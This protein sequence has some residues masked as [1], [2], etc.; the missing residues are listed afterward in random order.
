MK[1]KF[2]FALCAAIF[3]NTIVCFL[4]TS[5]YVHAKTNSKNDVSYKTEL[6][7]EATLLFRPRIDTYLFEDDILAYVREDRIYYLLVD[8]IDILALSI[9]YDE[10]SRKGAGWFLRED[11]RIQLDF[12]NKKVVSKDQ[13]YD[14]TD[15]DFLIFDDM[16]YVSAQGLS[17]W[18]ALE[19]TPDIEQQYVQVKSAYPVPAYARYLRGQKQFIKKQNLTVTTLP[20]HPI[21]YD[22]LDLNTANI[23]LSTQSRK[24]QGQNFNSAGRLTT[25]IEGQALKHDAYFLASGDDEDS[26]NN[27]AFRL[28]K[29]DEEGGL[30]GPLQAYEYQVGDINI[31]DLA[32]TGDAPQEL[33]FRVSNAPINNF[34][35]QASDIN[36]NAIPG[37]DVELYQNGILTDSITVDESGFYEFSDIQIFSGENLFDLFFYGPQGEVRKKQVSIPLTLD[38]ISSQKGS[39]DVSVSL[40]DTKTFQKNAPD[41][42]AKETPHIV[43]RYD[44]SFGNT[45][46][47]AGL[48]HRQILDDQKTFLGAGFSHLFKKS[49]LETNLAVDEELHKAAQL[50]WRQ[51]LKDWNWVVSGLAQDKEFQSS[52]QAVP[53]VLSVNSSLQNSFK[54]NDKVRANVAVSGE[55]SRL[56]DDSQ[57]YVGTIGTSLQKSHYNLSNSVFYAKNITPQGQSFTEL[58]DT[59]SFRGSF[60]KAFVRT[61]LTYDFSPRFEVDRLFAQANYY[62]DQNLSAEAFF[63]RQPLRDFNRYRFGVNYTGKYFRT[64]PFIEVNS[65]DD[66]LAGLN[67]SLNLIDMPEYYLPKVTS[68]SSTGRGLV[69]SFV[70]HDKDGN[71]AFDKDDE[72][73]SDVAVESVNVKRRAITNDRGYS[74]IQNMPIR[75]ATDVRVDHD[76]LPDPY[77]IVA[78]K[79][80]SILPRAGEI[81]NLDFPVHLSGEI[82]GTISL[83][84]K[85][86][87]RQPLRRAEVVLYPL[88][89][90]ESDIIK[91][92]VAIDG[93][94]VASQIPP[95][96]YLMSVSNDTAKNMKAR[97]P[98][99][100]FVDVGYDGD[101]FYGY[102]FELNGAQIHTPIDV[103]YHQNMSDEIQYAIH[104]RR[105]AK[106]KLLRLVSTMKSTQ[107]GQDVFA[108]L[109]QIKQENGAALYKMSASDLKENYDKCQQLAYQAYPC[110]LQIYMPSGEQMVK[111]AQ[112]SLP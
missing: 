58:S 112:T 59:L 9:G 72:I 110:R 25:T 11:W 54:P 5:S 32:L 97:L 66:I 73:L 8:V 93:F 2:S 68:Q 55:Y 21:E 10:V 49:I 36:G 1:V 50:S 14:I 18:L 76:S 89:K 86:G 99:P 29:L 24:S 33:G 17:T 91:S 47:Y 80:V 13:N 53:R 111:T 77:M 51:K 106:S 61:G 3:L 94:Y 4:L 98:I 7:S 31:S 103:V 95:G 65:D 28:S 64:S 16:T 48:R 63:E 27:V 71:F 6:P 96:Q 43:V 101:V 19:F 34:Q 39:Y 90:G 79:G 69:S 67:V 102:D 40:S 57:L 30:L 41:D 92:K 70:Y 46:A 100:R 56:R 62:H 75:R 45:L 107:S 88:H 35:F 22:W 15:Q 82:D 44:K 109:S 108:D 105:E 104:V 42:P 84:D 81:V 38:R 87:E 74:L 26:L 78:D 37:W 23:R 83:R 12:E 52:S 60:N 20:R 85:R